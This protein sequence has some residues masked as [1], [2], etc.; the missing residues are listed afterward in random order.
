MQLYLEEI[1]ILNKSVKNPCI[2][3]CVDYNKMIYLRNDENKIQYTYMI[4]NSTYFEYIN[5]DDVCNIIVNYKNIKFSLIL[6][7]NQY[8]Q[9]GKHILLLLE[10]LQSEYSNYN[11][12]ISSKI[13]YN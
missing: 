1:F 4:G 7:D 10:K 8:E 2:K 3:I 5:I 13:S 12:K 11:I 6:Q 9:Y